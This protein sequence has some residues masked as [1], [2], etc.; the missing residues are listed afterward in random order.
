MKKNEKV[1]EDKEVVVKKKIKI[2]NVL[3]VLIFL[4]IIGLYTY[5][6][7]VA[8]I[9][10]IYIS[11]NKYLTDQEVID[12][13]GIRNY[14][15]FIL[16]TKYQMKKNL[17][18]NDI[19]EKVKIKKSLDR[20]ITI[21]ITEATPLFL[22][23]DKAILSNEKEINNNN[24]KLPTII[25]T[26]DNEIMKKLIDKYQDVNE[27]IKMMISEIEY[28]PN[29]ID[30]ERFLFTMNDGNYVYITLYTLV[31]NEKN[32][33]ETSINDYIKIISN[34]SIKEKKGILYLDSGSFFETFE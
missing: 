5:K 33:K 25:N 27:E 17:L 13:S 7:F 32:D 21:E 24:Y 1:I 12:I 3:I 29:D 15:S 11:N 20:S 2:V 22:Y 18:K 31:A 14:P 6:L 30:K 9:N 26:L 16:S 4:Y 19:I 28:V 8:P 23:K 34:E 10:N